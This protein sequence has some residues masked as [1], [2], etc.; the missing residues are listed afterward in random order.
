MLTLEIETVGFENRWF[1]GRACL[2]IAAQGARAD[3]DKLGKILFCNPAGHARKGRSER[4]CSV[5]LQPVEQCD[6]YFQQVHPLC[7]QQGE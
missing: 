6:A 3:M 2:Q 4:G 7:E 5:F 1:V